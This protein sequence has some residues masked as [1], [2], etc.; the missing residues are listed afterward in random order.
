MY[1]KQLYIGGK[2][3]SLSVYMQSDGTDDGDPYTIPVPP[4]GQGV[5][6]INYNQIRAT[7]YRQN[8]TGV[9]DV[10]TTPSDLGTYS[11][12]SWS[13]MEN[14]AM[15]GYYVFGMPEL[16]LRSEAGVNWVSFVFRYQERIITTDSAVHPNTPTQ[17]I[18]YLPLDGVFDYSVT[19]WL[20]KEQR[21]AALAGDTNFEKRGNEQVYRDD[22]NTKD[23]LTRTVNFTGSLDEVG[24]IT[25][26]NND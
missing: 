20:S 17:T 1:S 22:A 13:E 8:A 18:L 6:D 24:T 19:I 5:P 7:Y 16:A 14:E 10:I 15:P 4:V 23:F 25:K 9:V 21:I 26:E 2:N 12:G 3:K 11:S